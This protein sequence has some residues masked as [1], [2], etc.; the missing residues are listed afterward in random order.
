MAIT[1]FILRACLALTL[2]LT[3]AGQAHAQKKKDDAP[4]PTGIDAATGKILT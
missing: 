2:A 4:P 1:Q 3:L